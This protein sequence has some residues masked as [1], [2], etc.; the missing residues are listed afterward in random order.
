M[1]GNKALAG[2]LSTIRRPSASRRP[3]LRT[4]HMSTRSSAWLLTLLPL[5]ATAASAGDLRRLSGLQISSR[6][7][8]MQFS[9]QVHWREVYEK[10]G[11]LHNYEMSASRL[12]KWRV[13]SDELC[14][15]LGK[16]GETCLQVLADGKRIVMRRD[17]DDNYPIEGT[18]EKPTDQA[19]PTP[20][21]YR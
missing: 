14:I 21:G 13:R 9:D 5:I 16:D 3:D 4:C 17:A 10:N 15:D 1:K 7:A 2:A 6:L 19:N 20:G 12:G 18:L 11:A 8:G